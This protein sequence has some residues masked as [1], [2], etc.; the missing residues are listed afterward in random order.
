MKLSRYEWRIQKLE[1]LPFLR[2]VADRA[3]YSEEYPELKESI[4]LLE[5]AFYRIQE[6]QYDINDFISV[7]DMDISLKIT[8]SCAMYTTLKRVGERLAVVS[9]DLYFMEEQ[10]FYYPN[11]TYLYLLEIF[12]SEVY[13]KV[14]RFIK[15]YKDVAIAEIIAYRRWLKRYAKKQ[16][17]ILFKNMEL[18]KINLI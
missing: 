9:S 8:R 14:E 2:M 11:S 15:V 16:T 4:R 1:Q 13:T 3:L 7:S 18:E 17:Y 5:D 6:I 10:R 12:L